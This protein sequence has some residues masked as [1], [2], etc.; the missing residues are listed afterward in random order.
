MINIFTV[1]KGYEIEPK[2]KAATEGRFW[3]IFWQKYR[4]LL[5]PTCWKFSS[6]LLQLN[7]DFY[8]TWFLISFVS[9]NSGESSR[10]CFVNESTRIIT[11]SSIKRKQSFVVLQIS[12]YII[13]LEITVALNSMGWYPFLHWWHRSGIFS[14]QS[15][16]LPYP[17][18]IQ[19]RQYWTYNLNFQI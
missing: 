7:F 11:L 9:G 3:L 2:L 12:E 6:F 17:S 5:Q 19:P 8:I 10:C 15:N 18:S 13:S 4:S 14:C 16:L 1:F